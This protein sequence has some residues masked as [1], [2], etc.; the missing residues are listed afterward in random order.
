MSTASIGTQLDAARNDLKA[1][2]LQLTTEHPD[3]VRARRKITELEERARAEGVPQSEGG[4]VLSP[5]EVDRRQRLQQLQAQLTVSISR[6]RTRSAT[7]RVSTRRW[8]SIRSVST[9]F[10]VTRPSSRR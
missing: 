5:A 4:D 3:V 9:R 2:E 10:R 7:S 1:L 8:R 6:S